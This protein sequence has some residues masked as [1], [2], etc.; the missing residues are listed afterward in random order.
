MKETTEAEDAAFHAVFGKGA[1]YYRKGY[2][3]TKEKALII[4]G[5]N[6][7]PS[8]VQEI[9]LRG[10]DWEST[11]QGND[12]W[13]DAHPIIWNKGVNPQWKAKYLPIF[14]FYVKHINGENM[15]LEDML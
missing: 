13:S 15:S 9:I 2:D 5:P 8:K 12:F 3:L 7:D 11:I 1:K 4:L 6:P 14:E 10:F